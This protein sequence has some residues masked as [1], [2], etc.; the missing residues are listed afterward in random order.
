MFTEKEKIEMYLSLLEKKY[1]N[2]N[3]IQNTEK[4]TLPKVKTKDFE[5]FYGSDSIFKN[6]CFLKEKNLEG[7][8]YYTAYYKEKIFSGLYCSDSFSKNIFHLN[9]EILI[10]SYRATSMFLYKTR[11]KNEEEFSSLS[12]T[13]LILGEFFFSRNIRKDISTKLLLYPWI[14]DY[15]E[16]EK[17]YN[18]EIDIKLS[19]ENN[20]M[21]YFGVN[22]LNKMNVTEKKLFKLVLLKD[23]IKRDINYLY[24]NRISYQSLL[25]KIEEFI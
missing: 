24:K 5:L 14:S 11:E 22:D 13:N 16:Y 17:E 3:K 18:K 1:F 4:L 2:N 9:T 21:L 23:I 8:I 7:F 25:N 6:I 12:I 19:K 15:Y 20:K 10:K